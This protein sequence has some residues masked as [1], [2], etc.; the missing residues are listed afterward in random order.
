MCIYIWLP[1]YLS[2]QLVYSSSNQSNS[3]I[4][5]CVK[6]WPQPS[7]VFD[8]QWVPP[9]RGSYHDPSSYNF[10]RYF[11]WEWWELECNLAK[12]MGI[13]FDCFCLG[14]F[15]HIPGPRGVNK[16]TRGNDHEARGAHSQARHIYYE[17]T[18][19]HEPWSM[20]KPS[21]NNYE[22]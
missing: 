2:I 15:D 3:T 13:V 21:H 18:I 16:N 8:L 11:V 10:L 17:C 9:R 12:N 19:K 1:T 6:L 22:H 5:R 7:T 14:H 4:C 20:N